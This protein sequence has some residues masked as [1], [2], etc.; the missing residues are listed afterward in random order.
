MARTV[1]RGRGG[2]NAVLLLDYLH[3]YQTAPAVVA[4]VRGYIDFYNTKRPHQSL[5]YQTPATV[6]RAC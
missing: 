6:Y 1:L 3:D 4:G 2:G 5:A